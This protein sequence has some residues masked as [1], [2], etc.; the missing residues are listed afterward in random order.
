M[1]ILVA[2]D[3]PV[4]AKSLCA[5][6]RH[7]AV[8]VAKDGQSAWQMIETYDYDLLILEENLAKINGIKLCQQ[9]RND[10]RQMP[11][12][13]ISPH[14]D[15]HRKS[16]GLDAGADDYMVQPID[17]EELVA[18]VRALLRRGR[19]TQQ[20]VMFWGDLQLEARSRS[21]TFKN[22]P[23]NLTPKEYALLELLLSDSVVANLLHERRVFSYGSIVE[24]LWI[25][26]DSPG[27]EAVRT[28]VKGLR[29]K[30]KV[31]GLAQDPIETIYG[32]GYRLRPPPL[33]QNRSL[34]M[35][36]ADPDL[37]VTRELQQAGKSEDIV[38]R[39]VRDRS[40]LMLEL[41]ASP[42]LLLLDA[43]ALTNGDLVEVAALLQEIRRLQPGLWVLLWSQR[44]DLRLRQLALQYQVCRFL[45]KPIAK[46]EVM[47]VV[48]S[49]ERRYL[50]PNRSLLLFG[51]GS[52]VVAEGLEDYRLIELTDPQMLWPTLLREDPLLVV[53][54]GDS[55]ERA[56]TSGAS[57]AIELCWLL[58][59]D[60][61]WCDRPILLLTHRDGGG[62]PWF[63]ASWDRS[64]SFAATVLRVLGRG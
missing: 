32:V 28:H 48:R 63:V 1:R 7:Y 55:G 30:L 24:H 44:S 49:I 6:L 34:S 8:D 33:L 61:L 38:V 20:P 21:V 62:Y 31:A 51:F 12:L 39:V 57:E 2:E 19:L 29:H 46:D 60:A 43:V 37:V 45:P 10:D 15:I 13:L 5:M 18:R 41:V 23:I 59:S 58:R 17:E 16:I 36:V 35:L 42:G 47:R 54:N 14:N 50:S 3:L 52:G 53:I 9:T 4:I 56:I 22:K 27:E 26:D 25:G 40:S 64:A 11:I